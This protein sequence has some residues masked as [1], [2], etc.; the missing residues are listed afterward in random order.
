M[1]HTPLISGNAVELLI[2]APIV[3]VVCTDTIELPDSKRFKKLTQLS[4]AKLL[5]QGIINIIDDQG[6][7]TLF[8]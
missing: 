5:G 8:Q 3:E 4:V 6:V 7:S 1:L 2:K